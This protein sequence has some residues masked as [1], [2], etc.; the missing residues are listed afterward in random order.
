MIN[1]RT[2]NEE[3]LW[4]KATLLKSTNEIAHVKR[5]DGHWMNGRLF[6]VRKH[7]IIIHDQEDGKSEEFFVDIKKIDKYVKEG[8]E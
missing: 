8:A 4:R 6:E 2:E 1:E 5:W 3:R 7:S